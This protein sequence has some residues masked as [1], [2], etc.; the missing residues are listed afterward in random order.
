MTNLLTVRSLPSMYF[1]K[2][3]VTMDKI[4]VKLKDQLNSEQFILTGSL[5]LRYHGICVDVKDIDLILINPTQGTLL[6]LKALSELFPVYPNISLEIK[7]S[8]EVKYQFKFENVNVD[9]FIEEGYVECLKTSNGIYV[10]PIC[11]I[12]SAK[13]RL[14]RPK[15]HISLFNISQ[16]FFNL[17]DMSK[18]LLTSNKRNEKT[19]NHTQY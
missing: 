16:L 4:L 2:K 11:R 19:T 5:A 17:S 14:D 9:V 8:W 13:K 7:A 10:N 12:I 3:I 18:I 1:F 15:D 6:K